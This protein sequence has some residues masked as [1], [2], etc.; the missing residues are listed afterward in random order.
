MYN[1]YNASVQYNLPQNSTVHRTGSSVLWCP[2]DPPA[3]G[4]S[5]RIRGEHDAGRRRRH[6]HQDHQLQGQRRDL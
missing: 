3:S 6:R 1:A 4:S 5:R 2:S